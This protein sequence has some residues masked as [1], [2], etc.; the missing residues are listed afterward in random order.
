MRYDLRKDL[1]V[2]PAASFRR[3]LS[4]GYNRKVDRPYKAVS[5]KTYSLFGVDVSTDQYFS[6]IRA[7]AE[8]LLVLC[9]DQQVLLSHIQKAGDMGFRKSLAYAHDDALIAHIPKNL[10]EALYTYTR[11]DRRK[12]PN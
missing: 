5:G 8:S 3:V 10:H 1:L 9:P 6:A 7:I 2:A 4:A 12:G 11:G